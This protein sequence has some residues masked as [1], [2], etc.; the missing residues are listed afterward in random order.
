MKELWKK[1][2]IKVSVLAICILVVCIIA[3]ITV[4]SISRQKAVTAHTEAA[5]KYLSELDYEQAIAEYMAA[6]SIEPNNQE[7]LDALEQLYLDMAQ[8]QIDVE[9]YSEAINILDRGYDE[10]Q[11][12]TL[13]E[14]KDEVEELQ[15]Q[16][17]EEERLAEEARKKEEEEKKKAEEEARWKEEEEKKKAEEEARL[18]EEEE[19]QKAEEVKKSEEATKKAAKEQL[20]VT[21]NKESKEETPIEKQETPEEQ[22]ERYIQKGEQYILAK[23]INAAF[24]DDLDWAISMHYIYKTEVV[25]NTENQCRIKFIIGCDDYCPWLGAEF[26]VDKASEQ[27]VVTDWG[28]GDVYYKDGHIN[29]WPKEGIPQMIGTTMDLR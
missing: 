7:V 13:L 28:T 8:V 24:K 21:E 27:G 10:L 17:A 3:G 19:K 9:A 15:A 18:K 26:V 12:K 16:K 25:E 14:K 2:G 22:L 6:L 4:Q 23:Y 11:R 5:Q 1:K 29:L 20:P